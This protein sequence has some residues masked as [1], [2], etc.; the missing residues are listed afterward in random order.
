[1]GSSLG[2]GIQMDMTVGNHG[3]LIAIA[4]IISGEMSPLTSERQTVMHINKLGKMMGISKYGVL[5]QR[6]SAGLEDCNHLG[7]LLSVLSCSSRRRQRLK[8]ISTWTSL[9]IYSTRNRAIMAVCQILYGTITMPL[10]CH[11]R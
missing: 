1:M 4:T 7:R 2:W 10:A 6:S 5:T 9:M 11:I 8:N 3:K